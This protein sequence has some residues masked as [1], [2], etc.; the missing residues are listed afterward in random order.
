MATATTYDKQKREKWEAWMGFEDLEDRGDAAVY[1]AA[2][3][4]RPAAI[5]V[6]IRGTPPRALPPPWGARMRATTVKRGAQPSGV[7]PKNTPLEE[8]LEKDQSLLSYEGLKHWMIT[9]GKQLRC[10]HGAHMPITP[11]MAKPFEAWFDHA[12]CGGFQP[13]NRNNDSAMPKLVEKVLAR[14]FRRAHQ[15]ELVSSGGDGCGSEVNS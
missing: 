10:Q 6:E 2:A 14:N 5:V 7:D 13:Y 15:M 11:G 9:E 12:G 8:T 4:A 1:Y 3:A